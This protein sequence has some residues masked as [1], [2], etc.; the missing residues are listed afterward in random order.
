MKKT[1][2]PLR[3][4]RI[5]EPE[6]QGYKRAAKR[7]GKSLSAWMRETLDKAAKRAGK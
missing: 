5:A 1:H 6:W 2:T 3:S 4:I 7:A